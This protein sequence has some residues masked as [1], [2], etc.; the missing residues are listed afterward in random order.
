MKK[1]FLLMVLAVFFAGCST[2]PYVGKWQATDSSGA[3]YDLM[4]NEDG[5]VICKWNGQTKEGTW[6]EESDG[7]I[8]LTA[9][10]IKS[11]LKKMDNKL[12]LETQKKVRYHF[13]RQAVRA[14]SH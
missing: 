1:L 7:T 4:L 11:S 2:S 9:P 13:T 6:K 5:T 10:D 3:K 14:A 8:S 12:V